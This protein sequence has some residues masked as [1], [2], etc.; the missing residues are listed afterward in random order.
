MNNKMIV[1]RKVAANII[2]KTGYDVEV[3]VMA[4]NNQDRVALIVNIGND[5][6]RPTVYLP[7]D[8]SD[9]PTDE[10]INTVATDMIKA[11]KN[12][13]G[14][15]SEMANIKDW[16]SE[17]LS[18]KEK[19]LANVTFSLVNRNWNSGRNWVSTPVDGD[20]QYIYEL[21]NPDVTDGSVCSVKI[22]ANHIAGL[23]VTPDELLEAALRNTPERQPAT[24]RDIADVLRLFPMPHDLMYVITNKQSC[25]G[26]G[27]IMY[28]EMQKKIAEVFGDDYVIL[29]SSIHET[30]VIRMPADMDIDQV[31]ALI[32]EVNITTVA[33]D[34]R[35]S[36]HAYKFVYGKLVSII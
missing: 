36:D 6:I 13:S 28:P 15:I 19:L 9:N 4:K 29:P 7:T 26:A 23:E 20:L 16:F 18:S 1:A 30:I 21:V 5:T 14:G 24:F 10:E 35:L 12:C 33:E 31:N 8:M 32:N 22:T 2:T 17:A 25:K 34:E 11:L 27:C 3:K